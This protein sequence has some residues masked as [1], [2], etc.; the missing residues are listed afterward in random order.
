[1]Q[2][3]SFR[4]QPKVGAYTDSVLV[5]MA[6]HGHIF[7]NVMH[8]KALAGVRDDSFQFGAAV[9]PH[10]LAIGLGVAKHFHVRL[11]VGMPT[12][13]TALGP[14]AMCTVPT[15]AG[16][17]FTGYHVPNQMRVVTADTKHKG[18]LQI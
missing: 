10:E 14:L 1:M 13:M 6:R 18:L 2:W 4:G 3:L 9:D 17:F 12:T 11:L 7:V 16:G 8:M 5:Y 15:A